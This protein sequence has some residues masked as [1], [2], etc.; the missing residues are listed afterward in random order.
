MRRVLNACKQQH[1]GRGEW[2]PSWSDA[3]RRDATSRPASLWI[4]R[5]F[6][7]RRSSSR[8]STARFAAPSMNGSPRRRGCATPSRARPDLAAPRLKVD[9]SGVHRHLRGYDLVGILHRLAA[10][11]L[12]D[13]VHALGDLAPDG[14]LA[15]EEARVVEA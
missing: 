1:S 3:R 15:V 13:V 5:A 4:A 7:R 11:D 8:W 6:A 10:L 9:T 14:V 12:V 2:A